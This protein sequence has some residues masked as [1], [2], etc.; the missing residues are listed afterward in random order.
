MDMIFGLA[1]VLGIGPALILMYLG[2][3]NYTYPR[4]EQPFFSDPRFFMLLVVGMIAGS[5]LF[6]ALRVLGF[7]TNVVYMV[8]MAVIEVMA[9]VVVMNLKRFRGQSDSIFYGYALG[10]GMSCG[11]ATGIVFLVA[12]AIDTADVSFTVLDAAILVLMSVSFSLMLGAVGTTVG[13][14]IARHRVMEFALQAAIPAI[15]FNILLYVLFQN[16]ETY[17]ILYYVCLVVMVA[18]SAYMFYRT[19]YQRLPQIV[20]EVLKME[21]KRRD[22]IPKKG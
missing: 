5:V 2:V 13:E 20:R 10:L 18:V 7:T 19:M 12:S 1:M 17:G 6:F 11:L 15:I 16:S 4:V 8:L 14:G 3:R 22:D 9:M 21:G